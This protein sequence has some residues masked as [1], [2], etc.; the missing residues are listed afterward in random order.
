MKW[1]TRWIARPEDILFSGI[2]NPSNGQKEESMEEERIRNV[3][4][5]NLTA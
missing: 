4:T 3:V 2:I 5:N 1:E